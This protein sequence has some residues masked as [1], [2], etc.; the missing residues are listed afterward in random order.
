MIQCVSVYS[1]GTHHIK[2]S[3]IGFNQIAEMG[4]FAYRSGWKEMC[5]ENGYGNKNSLRPTRRPQIQI[6]NPLFFGRDQLLTRENAQRIIRSFTTSSFWI[7]LEQYHNRWRASADMLRCL[8]MQ[9]FLT[10][11]LK[12][13]GGDL[14]GMHTNN[15]GSPYWE[16]RPRW[17]QII[18]QNIPFA[19]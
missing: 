4:K 9:Q 12:T 17:N 11:E 19:R 8:K 14:T 1:I 15:A 13:N 3:L 16:E 18:F 5:I 6:E 2:E 7:G 10:S